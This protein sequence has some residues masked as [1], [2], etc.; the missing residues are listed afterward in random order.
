MRYP[1][2]FLVLVLPCLGLLSANSAYPQRLTGAIRGVIK[3]ATGAAIP[4]A[5]V[6]VLSEALI[7]GPRPTVSGE[8]GQYRFPA[9]PPGDYQ[10]T[11]SLAGFQTVQ[12][13]RVRG[14]GG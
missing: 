11:V 7:G 9:L 5:T 6:E 2:K 14:G 8:D 1:R 12:G 10:L 4:G 3:D 13:T